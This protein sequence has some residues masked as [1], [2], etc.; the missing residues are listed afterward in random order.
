V[1]E[2]AK[3]RVFDVILGVVLR[4][5][6]K[7]TLIVREFLDFSASDEQKEGNSDVGSENDDE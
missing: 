2:Q 1:S 5:E 7:G 6:A 4:V 3:G